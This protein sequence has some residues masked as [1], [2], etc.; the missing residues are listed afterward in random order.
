MKIPKNLIKKDLVLKSKNTNV[1]FYKP[2]NM[3]YIKKTG[4]LDII[5]EKLRLSSVEYKINFDQIERFDLIGFKNKFCQNGLKGK[6]VL[7][8]VSGKNILVWAG[9]YLSE[10]EVRGLELK[11]SDITGSN[12]RVLF[13]RG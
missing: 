6:I 13:N 5:K 7:Y 10:Y 8:L 12:I 3:V 1:V 11:I 9:T 2:L 4:L